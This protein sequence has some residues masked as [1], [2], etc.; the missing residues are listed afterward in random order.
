MK[1]YI[2][3]R[4]AR[5]FGKDWNTGK[6]T[7]ECQCL[8]CGLV[9]VGPIRPCERC[10]E[11]EVLGIRAQLDEALEALE[12]MTEERNK[13]LKQRQGLIENLNRRWRKS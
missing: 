10:R 4:I 1:Q 2:G 7:K 13:L 9:W 8:G 6:G 11:D 5:I 3:P 12:A